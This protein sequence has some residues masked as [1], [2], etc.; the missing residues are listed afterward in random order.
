MPSYDNWQREATCCQPIDPNVLDAQAWS[1]RLII[2]RLSAEN[3]RIDLPAADPAEAILIRLCAG[4]TSPRKMRT[5][6]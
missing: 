6:I 2:Q 4:W 5:L 3:W 1:K